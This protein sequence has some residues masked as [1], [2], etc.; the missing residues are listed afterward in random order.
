MMKVLPRLAAMRTATSTS[1]ST[2]PIYLVIVPLAVALIQLAVADPITEFSRSRAIRNSARLIA[3]IEA[4]RIANGH[5]PAST[6][7]VWPD[8][9]PSIIGIKEYRYEPNGDSYNLLFEQPNFR[10]GTREMVMYNPRDQQAIASHAMDVI[11]LT[12]AELEL[13]RRRG[14]YAARGTPYPHWKYFWFD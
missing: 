7:S 1:R 3:D 11:R 13:D 6:L 12:A 8:Y 5:Y 9:Q 2:A 4:Y 10:L 14:Y